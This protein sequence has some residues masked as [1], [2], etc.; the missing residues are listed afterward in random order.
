[1]ETE[2]IYNTV[3]MALKSANQRF[4]FLGKKG[5]EEV[6]KNKFGDTSL[7]GDIECEKAVLEMLDN[8]P[9]SVHSEEHGVVFIGDVP[10]LLGTLDGIDGT[11]VYKTNRIFGRYATMLGIYKG[12]NPTYDDYVAGGVMEHA[13]G[14]IFMAGKGMGTKAYKDDRSASIRTT[15]SKRHTGL[16]RICL[17]DHFQITRDTFF[18]I[19]GKDG[20]YNS[21]SSAELYVRVANGEADLTLECTRKGNLEFGAAYPLI[22]EAG[23][24][25]VDLQGKSLGPKKFLEFGQ[26]EH[27][28]V[29]TAATDDLAQHVLE[30]LKGKK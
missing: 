12:T 21:G 30:K 1:M 2:E 8:L 29:I 15:G 17:D 27:L 5:L 25:M 16:S 19:T 9:I 14:R 28:P 3:L 24:A 13:S 18:P 7:L 4:T 20:Y 11:S 6:K 26:Q 22:I 23:G 10:K